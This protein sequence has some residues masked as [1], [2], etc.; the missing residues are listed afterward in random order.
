MQQPSAQGIA[1]LYMGNPGALQQRIQQEQKAKPG[2]PPDLQKMLALQIVTNETDA[3]K[4]QKAMDQLQQM[5]GQQGEPPT[6]MQTLQQQA[7]QKSQA[8]TQQ[9]RQQAEQR[10]LPAAMMGAQ[11]EPAQPE[12]Q[13][14]AEV[15]QGGIDQLPSEFQMAGGGI[16]AFAEGAEVPY[17]PATAT[18]RSDYQE[19][20]TYQSL[21]EK[22][23]YEAMKADPKQAAEEYRQRLT[24]EVGPAD[25]SQIDRLM[26]ELE[27]RKAQL[28]G[29]KGGFDRFSEYMGKIAEGGRGQKWYEAGAKGAAGLAALNKERATQ[30]FDLTKQGIELAQKKA[31]TERSWKEKLFTDSNA[32]LKRVGDHAYNAAIAQ[33]KTDADAQKLR[34]DA[35]E[36]E[37]N[38]QNQL[39]MERE[40]GITSRAVAGAPGQTERM[41]AKIQALQKKGTPEALKEAEGLQALYQSLSG[42]GAAG[43]GATRNMIQGIRLQMKA[44][45][46]IL[47][48]VK[49]ANATDE[50]RAEASNKM[51]LLQKRLDVLNGIAA[52]EEG[53]A[54]APSAIP[55]PPNPTPDTLK[56]GQVYDTAQGKGRW[57]AASKTFTAVQ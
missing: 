1:S 45:A 35:V 54:A 53:G 2:L 56:D 26:A 9:A 31:D 25:T 17:D 6:V 44:A 47:D 20:P 50:Q 33:G 36:N 51:K 19:E 48:P 40:R 39:L 22:L 41:V 7:Q 8:Q 23:M 38:R 27:K 11:G 10:G 5:G 52:E 43:V 32:E 18:R 12:A 49:G 42:S 28:E 34:Q 24:K 21:P 37:K 13:P 16:V 3:A 14:E 15:A 57:N 55:L 4:K 46:D 29:P 30:Q